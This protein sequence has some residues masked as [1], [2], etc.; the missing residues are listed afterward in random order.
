MEIISNV[1]KNVLQKMNQMLQFT[2][3]PQKNVENRFFNLKHQ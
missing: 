1:H 3:Y 2:C